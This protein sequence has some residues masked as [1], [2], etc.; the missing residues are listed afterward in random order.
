MEIFH[1]SKRPVNVTH[2]HIAKEHAEE[3]SSHYLEHHFE[4]SKDFDTLYSYLVS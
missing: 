2:S 3:V 4:E 1:R